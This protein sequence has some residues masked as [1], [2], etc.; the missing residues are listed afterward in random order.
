M[1]H[2]TALAPVPSDLL[3]A[4]LVVT[5]LAA[6]RQ[7]RPY[8]GELGGDPVLLRSFGR[9][10]EIQHPSRIVRERSE[11]GD[12]VGEL[13]SRM[14]DTDTTMAGLWEK[15]VK[16]VLSLPR[17]IRAADSSPAAEETALFVRTALSQI[18]LRMVPISNTLE[19]I[20]KG[21]AI[22][23]V[24]WE[25]VSRGPLAGAW[26]P[27][28]LIDRPMWRFGWSASDR[29][30]HVV[31][32]PVRIQPVP[33]P[34]LKFQVLTYGTKDNPW[35]RA[36]LDRLYWV[37]YLKKHASKYWALFVERFAQPLAKGTYPYKP[38]QE[39]TNK[40]HQDRLLAILNTIRTG[41]AIALPEG[42]DVAF[43][44]ATRGGDASYAGFL[45][46]LDRAEALLLLGEVDTSGLAKGPGSFAKSQVSN[47]VRLETVDHDAHLLGSF[48]TD[49]L[50][51]W[52]VLLNFGPDA[53][54]PRSVYDSTDAPD[55]DQRMR[56]ISLALNDGVPVPI[57]YY[58]MTMRVPA[59]AEGEEV[60]TRAP[61][62]PSL[63]SASFPLS[64][65]KGGRWERG[66]G[67]EVPGGGALSRFAGE[68]WGG[69]ILAA[70]ARQIPYLVWL[71]QEDDLVRH[72]P[73]HN[74]VVMHGKVFAIDHP[75]WKTWWPPAGHNCRCSIG[76]ITAAA[77]EA[78]DY[79][80][81]EP[82]GP[83]P[84][85]PDTGLP[86]L[87]DPGFSG[88]PDPA[89]VVGDLLAALLKVLGHSPEEP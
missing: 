20:L 68:G 22:N 17:F 45:S 16:A 78:E 21:V 63:A 70:L 23:E 40:E 69:G 15:R 37:W 88:A 35:G 25:R 7:L 57:G 76:V 5:A 34:P 41:T 18:P 86:A 60:V 77:A 46:W 4:E 8:V 51:R 12:R 59:P 71:T 66:P 11:V 56:G 31:G 72:R 36:L 3:F 10:Q 52:I 9:W 33:A 50:V 24:M 13:Y 89:A 14:V 85:A 53:P 80:G 79:T 32:N 30:L 61:A 44:E 74:H 54:I 28:D 73:L 49:T 38:G 58:R 19:A 83:W 55:R 87:P 39:A 2:T 62:T 81:P 6:E 65:R 43:L 47:E 48:E 84:I 64:R 42:L 26:M 67:G 82:T 29:S 1:P 27:V 75:I